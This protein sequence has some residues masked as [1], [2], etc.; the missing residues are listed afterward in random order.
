MDFERI[1]SVKLLKTLKGTDDNG[2]QLVWLAGTVWD[3]KPY[4]RSIMQEFGLNRPGMLEI[5]YEPDPLP[6]VPEKTKA[7]EAT[8]DVTPDDTQKEVTKK[9]KPK[10]VLKKAAPRRGRRRKT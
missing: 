3:K 10:A 2:K 1:K 7:V 4:P 9:P 6:V 8:S 5:I